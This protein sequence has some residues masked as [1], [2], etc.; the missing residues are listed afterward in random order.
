M[1]ASTFDMRGFAEGD[2]QSLTIPYEL[3]E[4]LMFVGNATE[5]TDRI[6]GYVDDGLEHAILVKMSPVSSADSTK[7][8]PTQGNCSLWGPRS[9]SSRRWDAT[10]SVRNRT[11]A[12]TQVFE[13]LNRWRN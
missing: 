6:G 9:A 12:P 7:S 3:G 2:R 8:T 4:E 1:P 10:R 13:H 5:I 11:Q